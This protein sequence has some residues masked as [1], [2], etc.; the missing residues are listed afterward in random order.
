MTDLAT[1]PV[2]AVADVARYA[3]DVGVA[4]RAASHMLARAPTAVRNAALEAIAVALRGSRAA[5]LDASREDVLRAR[6]AGQD[7]AFVDRLAL[8]DATI[9]KMAE[10]LEAIAAL[11][12]PIGE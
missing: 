8:T 6:A 7:P 4:A 11:P 3:H 5:L 10:G 12:D 1:P 2:A 9:D